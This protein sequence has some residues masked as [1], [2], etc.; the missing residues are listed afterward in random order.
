MQQCNSKVAAHGI[1][2]APTI[3]EKH[4]EEVTASHTHNSRPRGSGEILLVTWRN[5]LSSNH[6]GN[7]GLCGLDTQYCYCAVLSM[8]PPVGLVAP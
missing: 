5:V 8:P 1:S 2:T 7:W 6:Q 4:W 3:P